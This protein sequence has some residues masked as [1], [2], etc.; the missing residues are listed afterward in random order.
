MLLKT[1]F[2]RHSKCIVARANRA[3]DRDFA[4]DNQNCLPGSTP[5]QPFEGVFGSS[6]H[7]RFR[8]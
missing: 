1:A 6:V 4:D 8:A 7:H 3:L 5:F 2:S